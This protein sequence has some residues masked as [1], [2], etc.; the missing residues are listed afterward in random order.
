ML[1]LRRFRRK[2]YCY[3]VRPE[4]PG[5]E[6]HRYAVVDHFARRN[7]RRAC[8]DEASLLAGGLESLALDGRGK[9]DR[10]LARGGLVEVELQTSSLPRNVDDPAG[11][12]R[13]EVEM[14]AL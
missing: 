9:K 8:R 1:F 4:L 11:Q 6:A 5:G 12:R 13:G 10:E 14:R 2:W 7:P 3:A